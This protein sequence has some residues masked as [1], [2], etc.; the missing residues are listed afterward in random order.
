MILVDVVSLFFRTSFPTI[1]I[2]HS[3]F[4]HHHHHHTPQTPPPPPHTS[5]TT[6]T[7]T[8]LRH[9][10]HHHTPQTPPQFTTSTTLSPPS[11]PTTTLPPFQLKV[12]K[13]NESS[14]GKCFRCLSSWLRVYAVKEQALL[15]SQLINCAINVLVGGWL[16]GLEGL[17]VGGRGLMEVINE[18]GGF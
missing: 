7:T 17:W 11:Q 18:G 2:I 4:L 1:T 5:D 8:H 13:E 15:D 6:T 3:L 14:V 9:H 12:L 10:H 16:V